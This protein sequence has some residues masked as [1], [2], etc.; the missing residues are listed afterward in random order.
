MMVALLRSFRCFGGRIQPQFLIGGAQQIF[1]SKSI[2]TGESSQL[3]DS[4]PQ[5]SPEGRGGTAR[6]ALTPVRSR[7]EV[8]QFG[9]GLSRVR[10]ETGLLTLA[11]ADSS[12]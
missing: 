2:E 7:E 6:K 3:F 5:P 1:S 8:V 4:P 12:G 11:R 10:T 9:R